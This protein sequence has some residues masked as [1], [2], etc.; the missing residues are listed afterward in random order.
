M[1]N[2]WA[3]Y[4]L[5]QLSLLNVFYFVSITVPLTVASVM[6]SSLSLAFTS[7]RLHKKELTNLKNFATGE[8]KVCRVRSFI[9]F[10]GWFTTEIV[11]SVI[12]TVALCMMTWIELFSGELLTEQVGLGVVKTNVHIIPLMILLLSIPIN[13]LLHANYVGQRSPFSCA[14][15]ILS[16]V[17]P[18]R[19]VIK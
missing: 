18:S 5:L 19:Y 17:F 10:Q 4:T 11:I 2:F 15:G 8:N 9:S 6:I 16:A 14:H 12:S 7:W 3:F 1:T 13:A